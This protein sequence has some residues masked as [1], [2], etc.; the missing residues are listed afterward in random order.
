MINSNNFWYQQ[1]MSRFMKIFKY[2]CKVI[3]TTVVLGTLLYVG[4]YV[5]LF[6]WICH[7]EHEISWKDVFIIKDVVD[8]VLTGKEKDAYYSHDGKKLLSV[9]DYATSL[10]MPETVTSVEDR[11]LDYCL[12]LKEITVSLNNPVY[13]SLDGVL[14]SK[15]RTKLI[16]MPRMYDKEYFH[17]PDS[18]TSIGERAFYNCENLTEITIPD[19]VISIGDDAFDACPVTIIAVPDS[20]AWNYAQENDIKVVAADKSN[21]NIN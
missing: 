19:S 16:R 6:M 18:V 9:S 11:S 13:S 17:I 1:K 4:L 2:I 20:Y 12:S 21:H 5:G 8:Y 7:G 3:L 15:D 14:Y 10:Q